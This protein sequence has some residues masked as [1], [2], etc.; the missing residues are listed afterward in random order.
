MQ[1]IEHVAVNSIKNRAANKAI[2]KERGSESVLNQ[3]HT[4][5]LLYF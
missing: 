2:I 3:K 4:G 5:R 1:E